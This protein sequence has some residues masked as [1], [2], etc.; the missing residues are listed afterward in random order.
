MPG[1]RDDQA[2]REMTRSLKRLQSYCNIPEQPAFYIT[3]WGEI[4]T[5]S[6]RVFFSYKQS[7]PNTAY[8]WGFSLFSYP[9]GEDV[10]EETGQLLTLERQLAANGRIAFLLPSSLP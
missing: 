9:I 5:W 3:E 10:T 6:F 2:Q 8:V 7:Q 4:T 1:T